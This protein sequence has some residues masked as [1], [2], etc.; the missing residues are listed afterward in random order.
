MKTKVQ[1]VAAF[2]D[3]YEGDAIGVLAALNKEVTKAHGRGILKTDVEVFPICNSDVAPVAFA[4]VSFADDVATYK[5][6]HGAS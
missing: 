6:A 5:V 1:D 3:N 2:M 4:L